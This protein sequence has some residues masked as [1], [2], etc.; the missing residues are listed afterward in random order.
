LLIDTYEIELN[1]PGC[2]PGADFY[3]AKLRL[4]ADIGEVLPYINATLDRA[5]FVPAAPALV[6]REGDRGYALRS[7]EISISHIED[8]AHAEELAREI[9]ERINAVWENRQNM[10]PSYATVERP[11]VLDIYKLLPRTNCKQCGV[12]TC[13]A[14]AAGL[15]EGSAAPEDC[16]PLREAEWAASLGTLRETGL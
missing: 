16:P 13:M 7:H 15:A 12:P 6:W 9:V 5:Q 8:R 14:F 4:P 10:E 11:K 3:V 2:S 1:A